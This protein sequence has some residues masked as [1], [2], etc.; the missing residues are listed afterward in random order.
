VSN[1][2]AG[3]RLLRE[4]GLYTLGLILLR[5]GNFLLIPLYTRLLTQSEYGAVSLIQ[6]LVNL[7]VPIA[8]TAQTHALVKLGTEAEHDEERLHRLVSTVFTYA[9]LS[10]LTWVGL[11]A[12]FWPSF[13]HL[14]RDLPLWPVGAAGLAGVLGAVSFSLSLAWLQFSRQARAH[15]VLSVVRMLLLLP[16]IGLFLIVL[17]WGA[18][19]LLLATA[20]SFSLGGLLGLRT[21]PSGVRPG[22]DGALLKEGLI[23]G[24]PVLPHVLAAVV[25]QATDKAVVAYHHGLA[26]AGIY[27]LA[28]KLGSAVMMVAIGANRAW[29]PFFMREDRDAGEAGWARVRVLSF[30]AFAIVCC[31]AVGL[32]LLAPEFVSVA[33]PDSYRPAAQL[34]PILAFARLLQ[35]AALIAMA[36]VLA[37]KKAARWIAVCTVPPALLNIWLN[38][39]WIPEHG[40]L[41]AAWATAASYAVLLAITALL[42]RRARKVPF[43]YGHAAVLIA[44]VAGVFVLADGQ[45]LPVRIAL[46]IAYAIGLLVL[47]SKDLRKAVVSMRKQ[48]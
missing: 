22:I 7:L 21:L 29:M 24:I 28:A 2:S 26:V 36:V 33:G 19:G 43:K 40:A 25:I 4:G 14:L 37:D 39:A 27:D 48:R 12:V 46:G 45:S 38:T 3:V 8:V 18:P 15:T 16:F 44:G 17:D 34:V 41:G 20:V 31:A 42:G 35:G 47:D 10:A 32:G 5:G 13:S 23:Y 30:F 6:Q 11:A 1:L 9:V